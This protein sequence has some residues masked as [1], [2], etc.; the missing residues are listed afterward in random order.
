P[1]L[2]DVDTVLVSHERRLPGG[3]MAKRPYPG[4]GKAVITTIMGEGVSIKVVDSAGRSDPQAVIFIKGKAPK[5]VGRKTVLARVPRKAVCG[6]VY[7][8]RPLAVVIHSSPEGDA[9]IAWT[10][11]R[12]GSSEIETGTNLP[13]RDRQTPR[14]M[15]PSQVSPASSYMAMTPFSSLGPTRSKSSK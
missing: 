13:F 15:V 6:P 5:V 3:H 4:A 10:M 11:L 1:L 8:A 2:D 12:M 9:L 14:F 7:R